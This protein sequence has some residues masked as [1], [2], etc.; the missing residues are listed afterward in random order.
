MKTILVPLD[1][2]ALAEAVLPYV[3]LLAN[4]L[5]ARVHLLH[6]ITEVDTPNPLA[7]D[8][9]TLYSMSDVVAARQTSYHQSLQTLREHAEG[10]LASQAMRLKDDGI[11][12][13]VD[14]RFGAPP[15]LI[16]EVAEQ[17]SAT[18]IAMATHGYSGLRR[19]A[20]GSVTDRVVQ[21]TRTPVFVVRGSPESHGEPELRRIL[22]PLDGSE[23]ARQALPLARDLAARAQA[24]IDLLQAIVPDM[25]PT[26]SMVP[27][28]AEA[29]P[30]LAAQREYAAAELNAQA[31]EL[32]GPSLPVKTAVA[33]G[34]AAEVIV[35]EAAR[36]RA[37]L[38][39]MVTHGRGGLRRWALGSVA[40]KVLHATTTPLILVRAQ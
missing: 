38:I 17:R 11:E 30:P 15:D 36:G 22:V 25:P 24:E 7:Y 16:V 8:I 28:P 13:D 3:R 33:T 10:Y 19:W 5:G 21:A 20:L 40:D 18:L 31:M 34:Y 37:D 12:V 35:D 2:S 9:S 23:F 4:T 39:V 27:T 32:A 14:A 6:V 1:G 26:D 29:R